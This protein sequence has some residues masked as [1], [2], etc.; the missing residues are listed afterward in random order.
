MD[1]NSINGS[2]GTN[3][4]KQKHFNP[5]DIIKVCN[6]MLEITPNDYETMVCRAAANQE[7]GNIEGALFDL[8]NALIIKPDLVNALNNRG[9]IRYQLKEYWGALDDYNAANLINPEIKEVIY[10]RANAFRALDMFE[11]N[12]VRNH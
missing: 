2:E 9:L 1:K 5:R 8:N 10:N 12:G 3:S 4:S 6:T 11:K 7:T